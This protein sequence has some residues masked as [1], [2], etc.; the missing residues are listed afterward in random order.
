M[1]QRIAIYMLA[2]IGIA[3]C[4]TSGNSSSSNNP[5][6]GVTIQTATPTPSPTATPVPTATP[7]PAPM[8]TQAIAD[9]GFETTTFSASAWQP[10]SYPKAQAS[11]TPVP[12]VT[13]TITADFISPSSPP[14]TE[15]AYPGPS[16][17]STPTATVQPSVHGGTYAALAYAGTGANAV[18]F[19]PNT[20]AVKSTGG[21]NGICQTFTVPTSASLTFYVDEG[22][23]DSNSSTTIYADQE[24]T[25]F[26][27]PT[28]ALASASPIP[29]FSELNTYEQTSSAET[30]Y[31]EKGPYAL[32]GAPY[33]L[34]PG[35]T[36]TL[37]IGAYDSS[38]NTKY[39]TWIEADDVSITGITVGASSARYRAA[40]VRSKTLHP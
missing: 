33:N 29:L 14:F 11:G 28:S 17:T 7:T 8:S 2:V 30:G 3:A 38:P 22:G 27:G 23:Y 40:S 31:V 34:S 10:C 1:N 25:L 9:G 16:N 6:A 26:A 21:E 39:G 37:Y 4:S 12:M 18:I 36:A 13:G 32:T 35:S 15:G 24:A 5:L 20:A 19:G